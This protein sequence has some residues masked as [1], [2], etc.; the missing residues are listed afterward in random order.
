MKLEFFTDGRGRQPVYDWIFEVEK[1]DKE[2]Y[3]KTVIMMNYLEENGQLIHAGVVS[4]KDIKKLTGTNGIWQLR[5]N[6]HRMLFFYFEGDKIVFTNV[7]QKKKNKTP[8]VEID[9]AEQRKEE[10]INRNQ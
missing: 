2:T 4:H 6:D 10:Y 9:R 1:H 3:R 7:F 5:I 8:R